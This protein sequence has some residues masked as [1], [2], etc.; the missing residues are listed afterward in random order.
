VLAAPTL[1]TG[2]WAVF[3][4]ASWY[5]DFGA[6]VAPPSAFGHYNEHFVQ[7]LG[8]GYLGVAAVLVWAAVYLQRELV[9]GALIAFLVFTVPHLVI[10]VTEDGDLDRA[11]YWF[12]IGSLGFGLLLA[13]WVWRTAT[14]IEVPAHTSRRAAGG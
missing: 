7:D 3:A 8:S 9:Q 10:H 2:I 4:P 6:G 14:R 1:L 11:G 13:L 12:T 5:A